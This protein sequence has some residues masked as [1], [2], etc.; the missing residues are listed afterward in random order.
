VRHL[1]G[2]LLAEPRILKFTTGRRKLAWHRNCVAIGLAGGFLE[3]LESTSIHLIQLA[4]TYLLELFPDRTFEPAD[5]DEFNRLMDLEFERVRDFLVLHYHATER[6]DAPLWNYCR[7]MKIPESLAYKLEQFRA[8]GYVVPY[9][10]GL[11]R[12]ASWLAVYF[13]QRISPHRYDLRADALPRA[14]LDR[15]LRGL[16]TW[17]RRTAET[18]TTRSAFLQNFCYGHV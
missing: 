16:K 12:E 18:T 3:P 13:G 2:P 15:H 14:D 11:F 1:E 5:R 9:K 4:I 7:T 6:C 17:I 10:D 8:S